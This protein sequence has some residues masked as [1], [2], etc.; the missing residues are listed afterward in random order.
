[1]A[2]PLNDPPTDAEVAFSPVH[3]KK[4]QFQELDKISWDGPDYP[5]WIGAL[6]RLQ[7]AIVVTMKFWVYI[8][9]IKTA[10]Q[11]HVVKL[12]ARHQQDCLPLVDGDSVVLLSAEGNVQRVAVHGANLTS[13]TRN[14]VKNEAL[15]SSME[16][17]V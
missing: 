2:T 14:V 8:I 13:W 9:D 17:R 7:L 3:N 11:L 4:I 6:P 16:Q 15:A 5:F 12:E 1:M 10:T